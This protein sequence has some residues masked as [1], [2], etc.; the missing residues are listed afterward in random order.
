VQVIEIREKDGE[1]YIRFTYPNYDFSKDKCI[2]DIINLGPQIEI[3]G[4]PST[5]TGIYL[6]NVG[7]ILLCILTED[8]ALFKYYKDS[9]S[10]PLILSEKEFQEYSP[11]YWYYV[12]STSRDEYG[13]NLVGHTATIDEFID[14][15]DN[16]MAEADEMNAKRRIVKVKQTLATYGPIALVGVLVVGA[17]AVGVVLYR[18]RKK[19]VLPIEV[20]ADPVDDP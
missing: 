6:F 9:K 17:A 15:Y 10:E 7:G 16:Y 1:Q 8:G 4:K 20:V 18:K 11:A 13:H 19:A 2:K 14:N 12:T 5:I 3:N